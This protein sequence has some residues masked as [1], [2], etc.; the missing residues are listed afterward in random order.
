MLREYR[1]ADEESVVQL[2]L[3]AWAPVFASVE[4][5][6]GREIFVRLHGDWRHYQATAVRRT[7]ADDGMRVWVAEVEGGVVAFIAATSDVER[8]AGEISMLAVDPDDQGEGV[9]RALIEIA[10]DWMR[11]SGIRVAIVE[12][13]GDPGHAPARRLYETAGYTPLAVARYFKAL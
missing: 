5:A 2:S 3:R 12:T 9:G 8:R 7:L 4:K 6:L 10:T 1:P 11:H 13:G